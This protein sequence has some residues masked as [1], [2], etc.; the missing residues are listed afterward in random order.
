MRNIC[1][2]NV[3]ALTLLNYLKKNLIMGNYELYKR[4]VVEFIS[5]SSGTLLEMLEYVNRRLTADL[6][7]EDISKRTLQTT[8]QELKAEFPNEKK[9][10]KYQFEGKDTE[11]A[12]LEK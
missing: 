11:K 6:K 8:L 4:L 10:N 2:F 7:F 9:Y 1:A 3:F 5:G 12:A